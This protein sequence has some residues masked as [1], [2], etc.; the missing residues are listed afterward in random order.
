LQHSTDAASQDRRS[1]RRAV[2]ALD[3]VPLVEDDI[4]EEVIEEGDLLPAGR[5]D[6]PADIAETQ[7]AALDEQLVVGTGRELV[8]Q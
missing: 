4:A 2:R 1:R 6:L 8:G 7:L 3:I 5:S